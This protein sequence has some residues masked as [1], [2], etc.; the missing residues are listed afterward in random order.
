[1]FAWIAQVLEV[2][3]SSTEPVD[4]PYK[5]D[6]AYHSRVVTSPSSSSESD[7]VLKYVASIR[8]QLKVGY[9]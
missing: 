4:L 8:E 3:S 7:D 9:I 5:V 1:M 2:L 6:I